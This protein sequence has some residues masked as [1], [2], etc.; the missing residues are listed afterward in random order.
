MLIP[1]F[2]VQF[3]SLMFLLHA[4]TLFATLPFNSNRE[5]RS[6]R[7]PQALEISPG[8]YRIKAGTF[9]VFVI[10]NKYIERITTN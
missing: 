7:E 1:L 4:V 2:E 9:Y 3:K 10:I 5:N 8:H 6:D